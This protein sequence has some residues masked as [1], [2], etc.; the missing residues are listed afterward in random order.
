MKFLIKSNAYEKVGGVNEYGTVPLKTD[1]RNLFLKEEAGSILEH[2]DEWTDFDELTKGFDPDK[3]RDYEDTLTLLS[4]FGIAEI[5][6]LPPKDEGV[7]VAGEREYAAV[8]EFLLKHRKEKGNFLLSDAGDDF[9]SQ[10]NVR[11]R[12]FN[13]VE[14][15]FTYK[16]GGEILA[17]LIVETAAKGTLSTSLTLNGLIFRQN[18]SDEERQNITREFLKYLAGEFCEDYRRLRFLRKITAENVDE[19]VFNML[20]SEGFKK[21]A[22]L[23]NELYGG[24]DVEIY[25]CEWLRS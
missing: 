14:Y 5:E 9:F 4:A 19:T 23:K 8:S 22:V 15:N 16:K 24:K 1:G 13:N 2:N 18:L 17:L 10:S 7:F 11:A 12:Q 6:T 21:T 20:K 3:L 25:D